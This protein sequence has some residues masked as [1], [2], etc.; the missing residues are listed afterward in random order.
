MLLIQSKYHFLWPSQN[1]NH[2]ICIYK[3]ISYILYFVPSLHLQG[4]DLCV[5]VLIVLG[6]NSNNCVNPGVEG[7]HPG[8]EG[9]TEFEALGKSLL[10]NISCGF[11]FE[12][13]FVPPPQA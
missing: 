8:P 1:R 3:I 7:S 6:H 4:K 12:T 2:A 11:I 13:Y 9:S 5:Y 10:Q